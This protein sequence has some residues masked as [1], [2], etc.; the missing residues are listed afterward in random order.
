ME[1][2]DLIAQ[3]RAA[4]TDLKAQTAKRKRMAQTLLAAE[5]VAFAACIGC[6]VAYTVTPWGWPWIALSLI[7][8]ANYLM[9][10]R[11][12]ANNSRRMDRVA[13]LLAVNERELRYH[14]NDLSSFADGQQYADPQHP[15]T[16]DLDIFG[17]GS[18]YQRV[19]RIVTTDG[20]DLLARLLAGQE[21][22]Q[23]PTIEQRAQ[24]IAALATRPQWM[25]KFLSI[26]IRT[27]VDSSRLREAIS[28]LREV[29]MPRFATAVWAGW[30]SAFALIVFYVLIALSVFTSLPVNVPV[31]FGLILLGTALGLCHSR[32]TVIGRALGEL[33]ESVSAY[34]ELIRLIR[35]MPST[36][37][38]MSAEL[39][40]LVCALDG[41]L[42]AFHEGEQLLKGLDRR[43]N[44]LG[45]VLGDVFF[46]TDIFLL[47]RCARWQK[48][49]E[50][51]AD[52]WLDA[53]GRTDAFVSMA[54]FRCNE[55]RA[56]QA[57]IVSDD[58]VV[59]EARSLY[60][61][62]L[63]D[64]AV[65][66]DFSI[67]DSNYYI[68][69]GANMAGK[70]TFLRALG[71]NYVLAMNGLPVFAESLRLSIF[72]LFTSMRT[73]DDL[74]R[75][76]SYFNAELLRLQHLIGHCRQQRHTLIILDEILKGTNSAD[77]LNG[78]R[79]FLEYIS[80][81]NVT[82]IV[83]THDLELSRLSEQYP[84]RF[85]NYCFEIE[86]GSRVTYTYKITPGIARNQN[87]TFLLKQI[88]EQGE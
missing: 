75:G 72:S 50:K 12:D 52:Q 53:V 17:P 85:H 2:A 54:M 31:I 32:F 35:E 37:S 49:V 21:P 64:E 77:K 57:E 26:G 25:M 79:L 42:P 87:A 43:G 55:P 1:R 76:I 34:V 82:G 69:T 84:E 78:S 51:R 68:I 6:L 70:S 80:R 7:A 83:A 59:L 16:F 56:R 88:L 48:A 81:Q 14:A 71:I 20:S 86:L 13:D 58:K 23:K 15:Y 8:A 11:M 4:V 27:T 5:I 39:S 3:Y 44:I 22:M 66:N 65:S 36:S 9:A 46:L 24:T 60:H 40:Q 19:C 29:G 30:L 61:P 62:F 45:L 28:R 47:R 74:T 73:T 18:L 38:S 41:A 63:G 33:Q 10:R 67:A